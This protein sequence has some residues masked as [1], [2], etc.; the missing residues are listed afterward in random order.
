MKGRCYGETSIVHYFIHSVKYDNPYC[1]ILHLHF[2]QKDAWF[3]LHD[4]K[5]EGT[6]QNFSFVIYCQAI[7]FDRIF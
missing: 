4:F 2:I 6:N 3:I 7:G 5:Q 1:I